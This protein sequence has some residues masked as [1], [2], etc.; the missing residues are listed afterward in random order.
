VD[1]SFHVLWKASQRRPGSNDS[2]PLAH[3]FVVDGASDWYASSQPEQMR[4]LYAEWE[5]TRAFPGELSLPIGSYSV[6]I[7]LTE[8]SFHEN[9]A[10]PSSGRWATVMTHDDLSFTIAP[11]PACSDGADNDGDGHT[12]FPEDL[13]CGDDADLSERSPLLPCDDGVDNDSDGR[14]DFDP[15]TFVNP[16]DE[17]TPPDGDGDPGC[18]A[19]TWSTESPQCQDGIENDD[20][21]RMDYDAGLFAYGDADPA[22][23]D[24][25]C[26]GRP[27]WNSEEPWSSYCGLGVELA[28]LLPPLMWLWRR[29]SRH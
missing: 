3:L 26:V 12:D 23:P 4:F 10:P 13:G 27:W 15:D 1:S 16:G 18:G 7:F 21:G 29:R 14:V 25:E 22:G 2:D 5:S 24:P 6:R 17:A 11:P 19:P 9:T 8:E 20:D 28:L